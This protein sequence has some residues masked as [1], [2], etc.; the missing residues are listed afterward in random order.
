M[1]KKQ[2]SKSNTNNFD[3][4]ELQRWFQDCHKCHFCPQNGWD[5]FHHIVGRG[6]K[7]DDTESSILNAAPLC[8]QKCHLPFHGLIRKRHYT[9]KFLLKTYDWLMYSGYTFK[10]VDMRF[11][12]KYAEYYV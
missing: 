12:E 2:S 9:R 7:G 6:I 4:E 11:I 10:P 8:N 3:Y 5:C 1:T